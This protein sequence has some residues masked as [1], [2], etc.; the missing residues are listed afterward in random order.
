MQDDTKNLDA[1]YYLDDSG[2]EITREE[3]LKELFYATNWMDQK[4]FMLY[5]GGGY[6]PLRVAVIAWHE[7]DAFAT[8]EEYARNAGQLGEINEHDVDADNYGEYEAFV[9][10]IPQPE[11]IMG[12]GLE[13]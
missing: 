8:F 3:F 1:M 4:G 9:E 13:D 2:D 12:D 11:I 5:V 10:V 6:V 7:S